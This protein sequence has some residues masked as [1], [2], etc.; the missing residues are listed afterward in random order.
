[1]PQV[2]RTEGVESPL[3]QAL[4]GIM[5][6]LAQRK[7]LAEAKRLRER[8]ELEDTR[9][10][11][12]E[13][14]QQNI[15]IANLLKQNAAETPIAAA[16]RATGD[17][18][19]APVLTPEQ[20]GPPADQ[21][22]SSEPKR[23]ITLKLPTGREI[24]LAPLRYKEEAEAERIK[25]A[26]AVHDV[27]QDTMDVPDDKEIF[28]ALAGQKGIR[29][30]VVN[31]VTQAL[32]RKDVAEANRL[33]KDAAATA[34][35]LE[36]DKTEAEKKADKDVKKAE[37]DAAIQAEADNWFKGVTQPRTGEI[38]AKAAAYINAHADKYPGGA[39]R[40][41]TQNQWAEVTATRGT[42]DT[43]D[44]IDAA[45]QRVKSKVGPAAY[46]FAELKT[47]LPLV[48]SNPDFVE[49]QR[50]LTGA[51]N[52][53]IK[54]ITGSQMSVN[55]AERL[56]KGMAEGTLKPAEFE[57]AMK[58]WRRNADRNLATLQGRKLPPLNAE[59][60]GAKP[61]SMEELLKKYGH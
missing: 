54:R 14:F 37:S 44:D 20:A 58:I 38:Q 4:Q 55:E 17:E 41:L 10:R 30:S 52:L 21:I 23:Q 12:S 35:R 25:Q 34:I 47:K 40:A 18:L 28:G 51:K 48:A 5:V 53:E 59:T 60:P 24:P 3:Y 1:M 57:A 50:L 32:A 39:P 31:A 6:G 56:M 36:K 45:Y 19:G 13:D 33:A 43:L 46:R 2:I 9:R 11:S 16:P 26:R 15:N 29:T 27:Q 8:Q 61:M 49:F 42:L 22:L 7:Q